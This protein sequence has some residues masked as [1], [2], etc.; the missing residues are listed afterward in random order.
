MSFDIRPPEEHGPEVIIQTRPRKRVWF[1][2]LAF[3]LIVLL[4]GAGFL[5]VKAGT[6]FSVVSERVTSFLGFKASSLPLSNPREQNRIDILLLGFRGE[7][8]P[9]G[10]LLTDT[11]MVISIDTKRNELALIS[12]PRDTYLK[13]PLVNQHTKIN[14]AFSIGE[15]KQKNGG[16]LFLSKVAV[17]DVLGVNIDYAVA[18]DF[19]A[20]KDTI[21]VLGGVDVRV[22]QPLR[23]TKQWGGIDFSVPA[24]MQHMDGDTALL[25]ARSRFS[26][27][28]F[29]RSRRQQELIVAVRDKALSLG[30]L[31]NPTKVADLLDVLGRH[32]RTDI[33]ARDVPEIFAL[34]GKIANKE[35]R[36]LVLDTRSGLLRSSTASNGAYIL[37]PSE[38]S[39]A[40]IHELAQNIFDT[41]LPPP[42][43]P[44]SPQPLPT[45][46]VAEPTITELPIETEEPSDI[47]PPAE[48]VEPTGDLNESG[49]DI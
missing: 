30:F 3:L 27:S 20:F 22:A 4:L 43:R 17:Q 36:R 21:D 14:E 10:G 12:I 23:E 48:P 49:M 39:F 9:H 32:I 46:P 18:I 25:Y 35:P 40:Y 33:E 15:S 47:E 16:G 19:R 13:L 2:I 6:T 34:F 28:D 11:Q 41:Q 1:R 24:G 31:A 38:G 44:I 45:E 26:S 8:D 5:L 29:D 37:T 7:G 42:A